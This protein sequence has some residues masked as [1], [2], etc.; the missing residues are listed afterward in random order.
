MKLVRLDYTKKGLSSYSSLNSA[1]CYHLG[2]GEEIKLT[3]LPESSVFIITSEGASSYQLAPI[4]KNYLIAEDPRGGSSSH[5]YVGSWVEKGAT[6]PVT[7][8]K[9]R[10][11]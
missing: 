11:N 6:I 10:K 7:P 3:S 9:R 4:D 2:S 1:R 8:L 5:G